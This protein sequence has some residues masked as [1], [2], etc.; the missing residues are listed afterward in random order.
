MQ[1]K[2]EKNKKWQNLLTNRMTWSL[3]CRLEWIH[4]IKL[5]ISWHFFNVK[6]LTVGGV[7]NSKH[8]N[9]IKGGNNSW[10]LDSI[11]IIFFLFLFTQNLFFSFISFSWRQWRTMS[12]KRAAGADGSSCAEPPSKKK[13]FL[14][15]QTVNL[16]PISTEVNNKKSI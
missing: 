14:L 11:W 5:I 10:F 3:F 13:A 9:F 2:R 16:G 1:K 4:Q 8:G 12:S 7:Q 15:S 6:K